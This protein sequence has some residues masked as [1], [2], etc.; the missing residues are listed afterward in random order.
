MFVV[1]I[2]QNQDAPALNM[3]AARQ[4]LAGSFRPDPACSDMLPGPLDG[5]A[6]ATVPVAP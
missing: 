6:R 5:A 3:T 2:R 4:D 1:T